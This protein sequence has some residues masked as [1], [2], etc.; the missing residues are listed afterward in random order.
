MLCSGFPE[1]LGHCIAYK[2]PSIFRVVFNSLKPLIDPKTAAKLIF[3]TGDVSDGSANDANMKSIIGQNWKVLCGAGQPVL[4]KGNT[5]GFHIDT[6]WPMAMERYRQMVEREARDAKAPEVDLNDVDAGDNVA[7]NEGGAESSNNN[8]DSESATESF[9]WENNRPNCASC[10]RKFGFVVRRHHCRRC[11]RCVCYNCSPFKLVLPATSLEV[12]ASR[13]SSVSPVRRK[14]SMDNVDMAANPSGI[15][16]KVRICRQCVTVLNHQNVSSASSST[17]P[18]SSAAME[19]K[20]VIESDAN[21]TESDS[22]PQTTQTSTRKNQSGSH[23]RRRRKS[24][25]NNDSSSTASTA[26]ASISPPVS[27]VDATD[28]SMT[29][30]SCIADRFQPREDAH[31]EMG[32]MIILNAV[33]VSLAVGAYVFCVPIENLTGRLLVLLTLYFSN[34]SQL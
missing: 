16:T 5:P 10:N 21:D 26:P 34:V 29:Q 11:G 6:Y 20:G 7:Y 27:D 24:D 17:P 22:R 13:A 4:R 15:G 3:V 23:S 28:S 33:V 30:S 25:E 1:R 2:P 19:S 31:Q 9:E 18:S 8:D 12:R 32:I 14:S